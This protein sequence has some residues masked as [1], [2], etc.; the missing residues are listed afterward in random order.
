MLKK[1]APHEKKGAYLATEYDTVVYPILRKFE[2]NGIELFEVK[3]QYRIG[4][5]VDVFM[6]GPF[7]SYFFKHPRTH[8]LILIFGMVHGPSEPLLN[9]IR[10]HK[11]LV[12]TLKV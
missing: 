5:R 9:Y 7:V 6:G 11:A 4:G 3:G 10:E 2:L 1:Y 12:Q 8:K